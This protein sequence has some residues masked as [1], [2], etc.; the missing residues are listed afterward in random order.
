MKDET[1]IRFNI[2]SET[3][4]KVL[5]L[6]GLFTFKEGKKPGIAEMY[7]RIVERGLTELQKT[8]KH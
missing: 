8:N 4:K 5:R 1:N 3:H 2:D 7:V 6:Q